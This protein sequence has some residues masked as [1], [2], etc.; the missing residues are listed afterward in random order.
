MVDNLGVH[1]T[2]AHSTWAQTR[3]CGNACRTYF[4]I[5]KTCYQ[6]ML[7]SGN[8]TPITTLKNDNAILIH[9]CLFR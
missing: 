6:I 3:F 8:T 2:R 9:I 1:L 5:V 7:V 4:G